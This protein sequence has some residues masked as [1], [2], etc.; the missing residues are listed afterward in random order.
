MSGIVLTIKWSIISLILIMLIHYIFYYFKN[1]LTTPKV[2]DL[3]SQPNETYLEMQKSLDET[4]MQDI[5]K[6]DMKNELN[7]FLSGLNK[8]N[9]PQS[10]EPL[11]HNEYS[12]NYTS[13]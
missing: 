13:Y 4:K 1:I 12:Q 10:S 6:V 3:I 2:K 9:T 8:K 7:D 5:N 11:M